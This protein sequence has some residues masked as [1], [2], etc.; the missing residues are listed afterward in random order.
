M[1][2]DRHHIDPIAAQKLTRTALP[3][4]LSEPTCLLPLHPMHTS[5]PAKRGQVADPG[6]RLATDPRR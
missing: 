1:S 5:S 2:E 6:A 3:A 4:R